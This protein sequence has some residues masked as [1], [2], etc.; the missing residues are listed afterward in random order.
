[1]T[2]S[3]IIRIVSTVAMTQVVCDVLANRYVYSKEKYADALERMER[4]RIKRDKVLASVQ[5]STINDSNATNAKGNKKLS[6]SAA[7]ALEKQAKKVERAED[8][9]NTAASNVARLHTTPN[10]LTAVVFIILYRVLSFEFKGKVVAVLPFHPWKLVRRLSQRGLKFSTELVEISPVVG[11]GNGRVTD[12][13]QVCGFLFIYLMAN[14]SVKFVVNKLLGRKPP[15]GADKG[16]LSM[17]DDPR[18]VKILETLG[19]DKEELQEMKN[20]VS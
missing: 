6:G 9:F 20:L 1:M 19:V 13:N 10:I 8:D 7:K 14:L 11:M 15:V 18:S 5:E 16:I 17:V 4:N 3:D 12:M 2:A